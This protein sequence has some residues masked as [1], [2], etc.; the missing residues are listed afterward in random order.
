LGDVVRRTHTVRGGPDGL[1]NYRGRLRSAYDGKVAAT[2]R[3]GVDGPFL[4][5]QLDRWP[6][7]QGVNPLEFTT[8]YFR[9]PVSKFL[10][11]RGVRVVGH[12]VRDSRP[13]TVVEVEPG[14]FD[15]KGW[16][17]RI[18]V[19][20]ERGVVVR[21]AGLIRHPDQDWRE[22]IRI[23][24]RGHEEVRPGIWLPAHVKHEVLHAPK[25]GR[26]EQVGW[27]YDGHYLA[28]EVNRELPEGTFRLDFPPS[29]T[30]KDNRR[31]D[32]K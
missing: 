15:G 18:W 27:S 13:V 10:V 22:Y 8:H 14:T 12:E 4:T 16:K 19:D 29:A 6:A 5:A 3:G 23:E 21:R 11:G 25:A 31:P 2:L 17:Y 30:V 24:S 32:E 9:E 26:P 7:W 1:K 28:W 20:M